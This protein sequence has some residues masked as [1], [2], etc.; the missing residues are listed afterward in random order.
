[1]LQIIKLDLL[2]YGKRRGLFGFLSAL[3]LNAGFSTVFW[4]RVICALNRFGL[5]GRIISKVLLRIHVI[6][7]GCY[8]SPQAKVAGGLRLP[9]PV[10]VVI[11]EGAVVGAGVTLY[12][13]VTLGQNLKN[14]YPI[15]EDDVCCYANSVLIGDI[16]V[17]H[18]G[19]VGANSFVNRNVESYSI[20][21]GV[22][23]RVIAKNKQ[24]T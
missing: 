21:A 3:I 24:E 19:V 11:G 12:Q 20:V 8:L 6:F 1:M 5:P 13:G 18:S 2:A 15:L 22:P 16:R 17:G 4:Y 14:Q 10:G 23:A 7:T 9:H